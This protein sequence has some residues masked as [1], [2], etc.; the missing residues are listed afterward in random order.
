MRERNSRSNCDTPGND[1]SRTAGAKTPPTGNHFAGKR[2]GAAVEIG[3]TG[4]DSSSITG[5][6]TSST[7]LGPSTVEK[8]REVRVILVAGE[9]ALAL[10]SAAIIHNALNI[11]SKRWPENCV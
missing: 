2:A 5:G 10:V 7:V 11:V 8:A 6:V 9:K 1:P 4:M 3:T